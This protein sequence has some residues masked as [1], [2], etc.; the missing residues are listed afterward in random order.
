MTGKEVL[1][2]LRAG[3]PWMQ[4]VPV[5]VVS[6][7]ELDA[8][9]QGSLDGLGCALRGAD[10]ALHAPAHAPRAIAGWKQ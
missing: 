8:T 4:D 1:Q 3:F 5:I 10:R 9:M 2:R 6:G 7:H